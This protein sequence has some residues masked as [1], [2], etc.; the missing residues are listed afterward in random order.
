MCCYH[1]P[2]SSEALIDGNSLRLDSLR[3]VSR[4]LRI[5]NIDG[6]DPVIS[7]GSPLEISLPSL[8]SVGSLKVQGRISRCAL[9]SRC[10]A[11]HSFILILIGLV[12]K[13]PT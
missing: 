4:F 6:C 3:E 1:L 13:F 12:W 2:A 11:M 8:Q 7:P 5:C 10:P 9:D